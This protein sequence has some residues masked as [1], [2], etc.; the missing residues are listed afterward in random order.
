MIAESQCHHKTLGILLGLDVNTGGYEPLY[1]CI[2]GMKYNLL[3]PNYLI[4]LYSGVVF[5]EQ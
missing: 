1:R 2:D 5:R 4:S 3:A